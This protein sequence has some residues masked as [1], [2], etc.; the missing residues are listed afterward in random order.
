MEQMVLLEALAKLL[1]N[2]FIKKLKTSLN[3]T[4]VNLQDGSTYFTK[5]DQV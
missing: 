2:K 3:A 4:N 1:N 5:V